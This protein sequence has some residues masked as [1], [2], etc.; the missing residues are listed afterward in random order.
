MNDILALAVN[1]CPASSGILTLIVLM[2]LPAGFFFSFLAFRVAG[3]AG[4][5][6]VLAVAVAGIGWGVVQLS[7]AGCLS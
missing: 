5:W 6:V 4:L 1:A 3:W 2:C 7:S